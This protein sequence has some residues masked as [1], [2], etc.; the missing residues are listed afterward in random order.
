MRRFTRLFTE[1]D[2]T[3]R[4]SEKT[5]ALRR[6]F[7]EAPPE[8]AVWALRVLTGQKLIRAV[9]YP[10]L[11]AWAAEAAGLEPWLFG[12]CY[13]A[14]GDLS[15]TLAL[16]LPPAEA[17]GDE[18]LHEVVERR[19]L[20]LAQMTEAEQKVAV[21]EAWRR[22]ETAER[23][24]FHKLISGN[25]RFGAAKKVVVNALAL[26]APGGVEPAVMQHRLG[27]RS[28]E[29]TA[30]A[31]AALLAGTED[32]VARP[33]PFYLASSLESDPAALG[34]PGVWRAEWKW[35]GIRAQLIRRG[36]ETLLWSRGDELITPAF[37][38]LRAAGDGL[39]PGTVVDGEVLA[40]ENDAPLPFALLQRRLN[41]KR[42][43]AMLFVDVPVVFMAYDLLEF[44]GED[45]RGRTT[46][47]RRGLLESV[48][49]QVD[50]AALR[51]SPRLGFGSWEELAQRRGESRERGVEGV[52]L[53]RRDS[54]YRAGRT[55]G[56]WWKWKVEPYTVDCVMVYA[57]RGSG[58][59]S[60]LF[61]DYTFAVWDGVPGESELVPVA[62]AYSGLTD[63]EFG[64]VD[65][66]IKRHTVGKKGSFRQVEPKLVFELAF[67][68]INVS[69]RHKSGVALRFPRMHR[70]RTD[71]TP[72][73]AD[74]LESLQALLR[75]SLR[76]GAAEGGGA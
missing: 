62:K 19:I 29:P 7:E 31:F 38:E 12:E 1:V 39:P 54:P 18:R 64:K 44:G 25:F 55:R 32:D 53:K 71:K 9:P 43:E 13:G 58:R 14:V 61:T 72:A 70:W 2:R 16:V 40:Y 10:R 36:G 73:E 69:K 45:V 63:A 23:F 67:E 3:T 74:T 34:N 37:P 42:M 4:T 56:A 46:D 48:L 6:Y 60:S 8:D 76:G 50:D 33:Y 27:G 57:Q 11:K 15:E 35:D 22:F 20:P 5:A 28:I 49:A 75:L 41:R 59:R 21:G 26:A 68:G 17:G 66:F 51:R 24:V 65:H 47:E 30:E 52:M